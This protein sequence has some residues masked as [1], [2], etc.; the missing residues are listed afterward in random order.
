MTDRTV[1]VILEGE[2]DDLIAAFAEGVAAAKGFERGVD[3]TSRK[4]KDD[5]DGMGKSSTDFERIVTRNLK[6]GQTAFTALKARSTE[7]RGEI[8]KLRTSFARTGDKSVFGDLKKAK[9]DLKAVESILGDMGQEGAQAGET[10]A[11]AFG[12]N[13]TELLP[14]LLTNPVGLAVVAG[15]VSIAVPVIGGAVAGAVGAGVGLGLIGAAAYIQKDN[16][17]IQGAFGQLKDDAVSVFKTA[18]EPLVGTFVDALD[19]VDTLLKSQG[20]QFAAIFAAV[21]PAIKPIVGDLEA[22]E[23]GILPGLQRTAEGFT[24]AVSNPEVQQSV[25]A[26]GKS[27]TALFNAVGDNPQVIA[28][29]FV[30][31]NVALSTT[32]SI[33]DG[34]VH[35]AGFVDSLF[36]GSGKNSIKEFGGAAVVASKQTS[37]LS[38][39]MVTT[40][41][42]A[43]KMGAA[44]DAAGKS[45]ASMGEHAGTASLA[46]SQVGFAVQSMGEHSGIAGKAVK[47]LTGQQ[48]ANA[49]AAIGE[50]QAYQSLDQTLDTTFGKYMSLDQAALN[51]K[52]AQ[53]DLAKQLGHGKKSW[54]ENTQAGR[55]NWSQL[56]TSIQTDKNAYDAR[57]KVEGATKKNTSAYDK[58]VD[59]LLKTAAKAGLSKDKIDDLR[60]SFEVLPKSAS[61]TIKTPGLTKARSDVNGLITEISKVHGKTVTIRVQTSG[62]TAATQRAFGRIANREGGVY[63]HAAEGVLSAAKIESAAVGPA[64]YAY[65]EPGTGGEAFVPKFGDQARAVS[66]LDIAAGWHGMR[67]IPADRSI[68]ARGGDGAAAGNTYVTNVY[69][70]QANFTTRDLDNL[71]QVQEIRQRIGRPR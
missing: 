56:L 29:A 71:Q 28:D 5:F 52:Q 3:G 54:D 26:V 1:R 33:L 27:F 11:S 59:A 24:K 58:E 14:K 60:K 67:M 61:T 8:A 9:N 69:P 38:G 62:V 35:T 42:Y 25:V 66:I 53:A 6:N 15:V 68:Q 13:T 49:N 12:K 70:Q 2:P 45:V 4:V 23:K 7:L 18:T 31:V 40:H 21:E 16:P 48:I 43:L 41:D 57:V 50:L 44:T 51:V 55:N 30:A 47:D 64:R 36:H 65:A 32:A 63:E 17:A 37:Q 19:S 10:F 46:T 20:P 34:L 39:I 22:L